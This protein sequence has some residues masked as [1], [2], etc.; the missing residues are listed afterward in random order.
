MS[1]KWSSSILKKSG[2]DFGELLKDEYAVIMLQGKN[3]F[4]DMIYCFLKVALPDIQ[5]LQLALQ[6]G[7]G[8]N[9]SDYGTVVAAG[10]GEPP[11]DV[12][13][14]IALNYPMLESPRP[15]HI[16]PAAVPTEKKAWD[17]Y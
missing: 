13:A 7:K 11:D 14:E 2:V 9:A 17:E 12:K 3:T 15:M 5:R 1:A 10:K 8:F 4:G 16:P 6:A